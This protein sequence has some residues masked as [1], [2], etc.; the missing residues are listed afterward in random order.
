MTDA[1]MTG[2]ASPVHYAPPAAPG[3]DGMPGYLVSDADRD[4]V[5]TALKEAFAA[6]IITKDELDERAGKAYGARTRGDI[7]SALDRLPHR[8]TQTAS[9]G[10]S[11]QAQHRASGHEVPGGGQAQR[12]SAPQLRADGAYYA[13]IVALPC[14]F[15]CLKL[16]DVIGWPWLW[17]LAPVW[18]SAALGALGLLTVI[19][20][21]ITER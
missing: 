18:I 16:T 21:G 11:P 7:D 4:Q 5:V 20:V 10:P 1:P 6:G 19:A 8:L 9:K 17:V 12:T 13:G 2:P 15:T 14:V 3:G